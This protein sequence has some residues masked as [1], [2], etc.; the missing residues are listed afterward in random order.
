MHFGLGEYLFPGLLGIKKAD[1]ERLV[2]EALQSL[3]P[4]Y[5]I[6]I[7][8]F[9]YFFSGVAQKL[10]YFQKRFIEAVMNC[11]PSD[12]SAAYALHNH[13]LLDW[14]ARELLQYAAYSHPTP[15][16]IRQV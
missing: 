3:W 14:W 5:S 6:S 1:R 7:D 4:Q 16:F 10:G 8:G 9:R 11:K 15:Q 12:T 2:S 13:A